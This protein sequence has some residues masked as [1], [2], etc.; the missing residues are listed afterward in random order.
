MFVINDGKL[1]E[2]ESKLNPLNSALMKSLWF[3]CERS[4]SPWHS[5]CVWHYPAEMSSGSL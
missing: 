1:P 4:F 2:K 5:H 3:A